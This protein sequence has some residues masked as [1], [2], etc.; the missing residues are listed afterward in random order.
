ML[1]L[2][3]EIKERAP[4][5]HPNLS[6]RKVRPLR[7]QVAALRPDTPDFVQFELYLKAGEAEQMAGREERAIQCFSKAY[8]LL[9]RLQRDLAPGWA[10]RLRFRLGMS[11]LR[12]GEFVHHRTHQTPED[13]IFPFAGGGIHKDRS[14]AREAIRYFTEQLETEVRDSAPDLTGR[15][16]LNIAHMAAGS[17]PGGVPDRYR[18]PL[19]GFGA[20]EPIPRFP[21]VAGRAG[22][23]T[24]SLAGGVV[25]D[26][27]DE[28]G[29]LDLV[30]STHDPAGQI[31]FFANDGRGSF[32]DRTAEAFL[33]GILGGL[34]LVHADYDDDG[35]LDVLMLRGAW[36]GAYGRLPKSLL[37]N[38][39]DG[40]FTDVTFESGLGEVHYPTQTASWAD[41]DNDGDLD[42]YVGNETTGELRAPSQLF[43]N[44][45]DG[46]FEDV[47]PLAGV[48]NDGFTKAVIWGDYDSDRL[49]DLYV[50]NIGGPNR[51]YRNEGTGRFTDV[52][53][54]LGVTEPV[55]SFASWFWDVDNDGNL[56]LFASAYDA[57][58]SDIVASA[59]GQSFDAQVPRL[60]RGDGTGRFTAVER[61]YGLTRPSAPMGANFGDLDNDG[62]L[63]FYLGTGYMASH[64][65]MPNVMYRSVGGR[66][67]ADVTVQGGFGHLQKGHGIAFADLDGDGDQEV[68]AQMGGALPG[69]D[70][71]D[72]LFENPGFGNHFLHVRLVGVESSRSAIGA[73]IR[74]RVSEGGRER[75]I[76]RHVNSGGT[77]GANPLRQTLGFGKADRLER[78]EVFWPSSNRTQTL[79]GIPMDRAVTIVEGGEGFWMVPSHDEERR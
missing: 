77:F 70:F 56:D 12:L 1:A 62:Y 42:V 29:D 79:G 30:V 7:E 41:Y 63:D 46:F 25:A 75:S 48:T 16:L 8:A 61:E 49:P 31:R 73:R 5:E 58:V 13:S 22:V 17:Y 28:D 78:L 68:F 43:V 54:E 4:E 11:Y 55:V 76:Y 21:N 35:D 66:T 74:A 71:D 57:Q 44:R 2:L 69:D 47:A 37:R 39:G 23:A 6:D 14:Y 64:G 18:I 10:N 32:R 67:F 51:L 36:L 38:N 34:N 60:Y 50:S 15:W 26:D 19:E 52:A 65:L 59:L 3:Q 33:S 53:P 20:G 72:A 40:T 45:G 9:P 27:M 24:F